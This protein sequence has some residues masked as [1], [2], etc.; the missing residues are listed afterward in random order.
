MR[1]ASEC[2]TTQLII[3]KKREIFHADIR[4]T[5]KA[6]IF[7]EKRLIYICME[8]DQKSSNEEKLQNPPVIIE[9]KIKQIYLY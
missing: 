3:S 6:S 2:E 1:S 9:K 7:N 5:Q 4:K 8:E